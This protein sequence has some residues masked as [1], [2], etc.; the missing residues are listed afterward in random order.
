MGAVGDRNWR[1]AAIG[2][3]IC[4]RWW[5]FVWRSCWARERTEKK[6]RRAARRSLVCARAWQQQSS[7][8]SSS[9]S[10]ARRLGTWPGPPPSSSEAAARRARSPAAPSRSHQAPLRWRSEL[11]PRQPPAGAGAVELRGGGAGE[12]GPWSEQATRVS[13]VPSRSRRRGRPWPPTGL[14]PG[15]LE[16]RHGHAPPAGELKLCRAPRF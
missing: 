7:G 8:E 16:L 14:A 10:K 2:G 12:L 3:S 6:G 9:N 5:S 1:E 15:N 11:G 13:S 4:S